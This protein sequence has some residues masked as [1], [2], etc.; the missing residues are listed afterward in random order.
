MPTSIEL[1]SSIIRQSSVSE[2]LPGT[3]VLPVT[4]FHPPFTYQDV[5]NRENSYSFGCSYK[6]FSK[7]AFRAR[8][9]RVWPKNQKSVPQPCYFAASAP[10]S[11]LRPHK[12][13]QPPVKDGWGV[14]SKA[15]FGNGHP[16]GVC[17]CQRR[18][19]HQRTKRGKYL[20][21]C[22]SS[23]VITRGQTSCAIL[24]SLSVITSPVCA[25][26]YKSVK[27]KPFL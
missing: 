27:S 25:F 15:Q 4:L 8:R 22:A 9:G 21:H 6:N 1:Y 20:F 12:R 13:N 16:V 10:S 23:H 19:N 18:D 17:Q 14:S 26:T 3:K 5:K 7:P 11:F 24:V 2:A